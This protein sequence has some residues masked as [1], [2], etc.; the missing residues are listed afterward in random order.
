MELVLVRHGETELNRADVFR[1]RADPPLN[2]RGLRQAEAASRGLA[3]LPLE[4]AYASPLAR[5]VQT[6]RIIAE[7][8]RVEV[9]AHPLFIDV[10]YGEWSEKDIVEVGR[11]WPREFSLWQEDPAS[12]R[13]PG[14]ESLPE[15]RER[16]EKGL[17]LL[18]RRH[19][20]RVL[21]VGHK[22]VNR[23]ILCICLGL[24]LEGIWRLDQS[25]GAI[26]LIDEAPG[27][28]LLRR[29]NDVSHLSGCASADQRT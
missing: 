14:G 15:V 26:N 25:N 18:R 5:A 28:W 24:G 11:R 23:I 8:H 3:G 9:E 27:G 29:M 6:A 10:D 4:A 17:E 16:L 22:V 12:L 21:L 20:G 13:F 19:G 2:E 7:P 1:G